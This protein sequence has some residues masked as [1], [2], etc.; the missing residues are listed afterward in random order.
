MEI[1]L[2]DEL[3][4]AERRDLPRRLDPGE[5]FVPRLGGELAL[6]DQAP[7]PLADRGDPARQGIGNDVDQDH[8]IAALR[9]HLGDAMAH[10]SRAHHADRLNLAH[11][12]SYLS[13]PLPHRAATGVSS[14]RDRG[15]GVK[16][17]GLTPIRIPLIV[18]VLAPLQKRPYAPN[19]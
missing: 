19:A 9:R 4:A 11:S 6:L 15:A 1:E 10:G 18:E 3:R 12:Y 7:E 17:E 8:L 16:T 2:D 14:V 13:T 5:G